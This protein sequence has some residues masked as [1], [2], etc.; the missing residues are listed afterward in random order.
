MA[1]S[2]E[3]NR[4]LITGAGGGLGR[5]HAVLMS[6]RGA[7]I[8]IQ[9]IDTER[10]A[11][12]ADLV[13]ETGRK[14]TVLV[15]DIRNVNKFCEEVQDAG[16]IDVLVNNAGVG[17]RGRK[18]EEIT[19]EIFDEMFDVHVRGS[20]FSAQAVL[21]QMK[22]R[23][24]GKIINTSSIFAMGGHYEASHY[25]AAKSAISGLTKSWARELAPWN[26]TVNAVAP[27]FVETDM[28]RASN[29][30]EKIAA[31]EEAMPLGRLCKPRDISHTVAWLASSDTEMIT[32][33]V[34]SPNAGQV[35]VGY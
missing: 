10:A 23:K 33:Q 17:G 34:I 20:F 15:S 31:L 6:E 12:T 19:P 16:R 7:D 29:S 14:V 1:N 28:T 30:P 21:P 4:I 3:E 9:D 26:I 35:I 32:G 11:E 22:K 8:I 27:G 13:R 2:L 5:S 25:A 18:I 24:S